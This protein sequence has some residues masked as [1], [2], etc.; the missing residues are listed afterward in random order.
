MICDITSTKVLDMLPLNYFD[1]II[2]NDVFEHVYDDFKLMSNLDKL[3]KDH[4]TLYFTIPNGLHFFDYVEREPHNHKYGLSR[5]RPCI[6]H[7]MGVNAAYYRY[8]EHYV[9]LF[10]YFGYDELLPIKP[11]DTTTDS[12]RNQIILEMKKRLEKVERTLRDNFPSNDTSLSKEVLL[13]LEKY[14]L[15]FDRDAQELEIPLLK[16]KYET[17]FWEG[18]ARRKA[19]REFQKV[20]YDVVGAQLNTTI[21]ENEFLR[22]KYE[23]L[24]QSKLG[25]IQL[26]I[27]R[28][29]SK[30]KR[31]KSRR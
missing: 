27:W 2:V 31:L 9:A 4:C 20:Q 23:S 25:K 29:R 14:H 6:W 15:E 1:V 7:K 11:D 8:W 3:A 21:K 24:A 16:F 12:S 30:F 13:E 10:S 22:Q 26:L 28:L 18:I 5:L 19:R 17:Q